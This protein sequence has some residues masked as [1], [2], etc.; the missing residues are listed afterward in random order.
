[1]SAAIC[2]LRLAEVERRVGLKKSAIYARIDRGEFPAPVR[3]G[4]A[5]RWLSNEIDAYV[6]RAANDSDVGSG[7]GSGNVGPQKTR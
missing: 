3:D 1:M 7:M 4:G 2:R 6:A 5:S